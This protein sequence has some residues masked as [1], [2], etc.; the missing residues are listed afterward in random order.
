MVGK[1]IGANGVNS[2]IITNNSSNSIRL[3]EPRIKKYDK[4][5]GKLY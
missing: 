2:N 5:H 4:S 3:E 1:K